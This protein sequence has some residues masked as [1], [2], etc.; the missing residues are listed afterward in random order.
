ME[1]FQKRIE[2]E[3]EELDNKL[4]ALNKFIVGDIFKKLPKIEQVYLEAQLM[5]MEQY[6][7][8]LHKRIALF[9]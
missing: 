2:V 6:S 9:K 3:K 4:E 8:I 1:E 7:N 5:F